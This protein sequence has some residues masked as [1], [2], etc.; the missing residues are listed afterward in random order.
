[1]CE[2]GEREEESAAGKQAPEIF[3]E[4]PPPRLFFLGWPNDELLVDSDPGSE[5]AI[6]CAADEFVRN[7]FKLLFRLTNSVLDFTRV[8][9]SIVFS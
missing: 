1:M 7:N 8:S 5:F 3:P 6:L 2:R 4:P 9:L